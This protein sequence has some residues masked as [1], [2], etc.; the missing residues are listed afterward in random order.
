MGKSVCLQWVCVCAAKTACNVYK[1]WYMQSLQ[2]SKEGKFTRHSH[3]SLGSAQK[4]IKLD[5]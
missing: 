2:I 3:K 1:L 5:K 4:I